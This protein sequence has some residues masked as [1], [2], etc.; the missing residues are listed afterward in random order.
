MY[1]SE[2]SC[3]LLTMSVRW[4]QQNAELHVWSVLIRDC[5]ALA[6]VLQEQELNRSTVIAGLKFRAFAWTLQQQHKSAGGAAG[7]H[8][9][10]NSFQQDPSLF[11]TACLTLFWALI[12]N[13]DPR[14]VTAV[15]L[16]G[17]HGHAA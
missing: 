2:G 13:A 3:T 6:S 10:S 8:P 14:L 17:V 7:G 16:S 12:S 11:D 5:W 1:M 15:R 9:R 4:G